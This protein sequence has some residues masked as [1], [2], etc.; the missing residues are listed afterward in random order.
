MEIIDREVDRLMTTFTGWLLNGDGEGL[1]PL[2]QTFIVGKLAQILGPKAVMKMSGDEVALLSRERVQKTNEDAAHLRALDKQTEKWLAKLR[3]T[4]TQQIRREIL[5]ADKQWQTEL[6]LRDQAGNLQKSIWSKLRELA[7]GGLFAA[8]KEAVAPIIRNVDSLMQT[9]SAAYLQMGQVIALGRGTEVY[10]IP[11]MT[12]CI[13][14][15]R[16]HIDKDGSPKVYT[17]AEVI[18][19]SNIGVKSLDWTFVMGP[20][21]PNCYCVLYEVGIEGSPGPDENL[22]EAYDISRETGGKTAKAA[23][24]AAKE[25]LDAA[26]RRLELAQQ[27]EGR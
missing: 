27:L 11:R 9:M 25:R 6:F 19:N 20:V 2:E 8:I 3:E 16:L 5:R 15:F 18:G 7:V 17:V 22:S 14:C 13:H 10:K 24:E 23:V 26:K 4:V 21:H 1:G 12:A